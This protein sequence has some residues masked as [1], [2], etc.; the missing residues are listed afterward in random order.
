MSGIHGYSEIPKGEAVLLDELGAQMIRLF[1]TDREWTGDNKTGMIVELGGRLNK[2]PDRSLTSYLMTVEQA[3]ELAGEIAYAVAS[4][5][6]PDLM[7]KF[8]DALAKVRK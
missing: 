4:C 6:D 5:E 2:M 7:E 1:E 8:N 3:A